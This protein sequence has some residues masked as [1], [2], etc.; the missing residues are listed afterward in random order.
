MYYWAIQ[1]ARK[2][3]KLLLFQLVIKTQDELDYKSYVLEV[4]D[5]TPTNIRS[6]NI[7]LSVLYT[8]S[9][10]V[11][12]EVQHSVNHSLHVESASF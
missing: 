1:R 8:A 7:K 2:T 9:C 10:S 11:A 12:G 5:D 6:Q 4:D 3:H